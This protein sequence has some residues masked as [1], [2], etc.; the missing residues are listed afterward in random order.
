MADYEKH[1]KNLE[2][3]QGSSYIEKLCKKAVLAKIPLAT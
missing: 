3:V 2:N 1:L